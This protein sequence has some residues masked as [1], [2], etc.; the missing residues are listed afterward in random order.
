MSLI[1][2]ISLVILVLTLT[3]GL[4]VQHRL[5][6]YL[7]SIDGLVGI[8]NQNE[9]EQYLFGSY[10]RGETLPDSDI[11]LRIDAGEI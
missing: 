1:N 8:S 9:M 5:K 2:F 7:K 11:D 10:D 6:K 3:I 4:A